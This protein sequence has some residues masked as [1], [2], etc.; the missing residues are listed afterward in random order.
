MHTIYYSIYSFVLA[1]QTTISN[2]TYAGG[3]DR[4]LQVMFI[5]TC[6]SAASIASGGVHCAFLKNDVRVK[7]A[8]GIVY[9]NVLSSAAPLYSSLYRGRLQ[10]VL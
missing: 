5:Y 6:A 9:K 8:V 2:Q 3:G 4:Y 1:R 10:C 7:T